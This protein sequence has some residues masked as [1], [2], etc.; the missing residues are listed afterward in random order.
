[1]R[2]LRVNNS[3]V[4]KASNVAVNSLGLALLTWLCVTFALPVHAQVHDYGIWSIPENPKP[5]PN[6]ETLD[7][8]LKRYLT[9]YTKFGSYASERA[10]APIPLARDIRK[11]EQV[12]TA[13]KATSLLSYLLYENGKIVVDE[14]SPSD[15]FGALVNND[16]KF[17]SMSLGKSMVSYL[18][19][20]AVCSGVVK[21]LDEKVS[22]WPLLAGTLYQNATLLDLINMRAGDQQYVNEQKGFINSK[23]RQSNPNVHSVKAN[24]NEELKDSVPAA[25]SFN[26]NSMA[27]NLV[28]N[29]IIFRS[30]GKFDALMKKMF[31]EKVGISDSVFFLKQPRGDEGDGLAVATFYANRYDYFRIAK[32]M[33]DDWQADT[34]EGR[35]LKEIYK[36]RVAKQGEQTRTSNPS[37]PFWSYR[38]YGGFFHTDFNN[39][40]SGRNIMSFQGYGGQM[41][42]ID[43]DQGR[44]VSTHA[45]HNDYDWKRLVNGVIDTGRFRSGF[46]N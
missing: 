45:I 42:V 19:G 28:L 31:Q 41:I 9:D 39:F 18:L 12:I 11:E 6:K 43:F 38:G 40:K 22:D 16:T 35:Y 25:A 27:P 33:L 21:G 3:Y 32:A 44:I 14:I 37:G 1:M 17:F 23:R 29:Y 24:L 30:G 13:L 4:T 15:R 5:T 20:H 2:S 26:Y 7:F 10:K 46:W 8:Y 36:R 34:C